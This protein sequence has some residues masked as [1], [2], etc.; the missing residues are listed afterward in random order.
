MLP[1]D[2]F[3]RCSKLPDT[4]DREER[5]EMFGQVAQELISRGGKANLYVGGSI[6]ACLENGGNLERDYLKITAPKS[7]HF[8]PSVLWRRI[9]ER[10]GSSR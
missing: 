6:L 7:S 4:V 8:T 3:G 5:V 10:L 1:A 9:R 2:P